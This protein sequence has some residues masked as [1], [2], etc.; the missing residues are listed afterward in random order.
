[1]ARDTQHTAA[2]P[3]DPY[4]NGESVSRGERDHVVPPRA[5]RR[6]P[7]PDTPNAA[8]RSR[9]RGKRADAFLAASGVLPPLSPPRNIDE[10]TE[11]AAEEAARE[12]ACSGLTL[13]ACP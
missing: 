13:D 6:T 1:M 12:A 3:T 2:S 11:M 10:M 8:V 7:V 5:K 4:R 9:S